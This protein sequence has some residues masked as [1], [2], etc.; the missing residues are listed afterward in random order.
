MAT[1][2]VNPSNKYFLKEPCE[3]IYTSSFQK[4]FGD[5]LDEIEQHTETT[6]LSDPTDLCIN[7]TTG[8]T[9]SRYSLSNVAVSQICRTLCPGLFKVICSLLNYQAGYDSAA[10]YASK[11]AYE[12]FNKVLYKRFALLSDKSIIKHTDNN[13][14]NGLIGKGYKYLSNI[15]FFDFVKDAI[16]TS[17]IPLKFNNASIYNRTVSI[18]YLNDKPISLMPN[19]YYMGIN[20]M[21]S[22][23]ADS[24]LK[25]SYILLEYNSNHRASTSV[26]GGR[27]IHTGRDFKKRV[28]KTLYAA[29]NNFNENNISYR[30]LITANLA[31]LQNTN[32]GFKNKSNI[33]LDEYRDKLESKLIQSKVSSQIA[34]RILNK[35]LTPSDYTGFIDSINAKVTWPTKTIYDFFLAVIKEATNKPLMHRFLLEKLAYDL[36]IGKSKLFKGIL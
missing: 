27:L 20:F 6:L 32:L 33:Q 2:S 7:T 35:T 29:V 3:L 36:L 13:E 14:I 10:T 19:T 24:S 28:I 26:K 23:I 9:I 12:I 4:A 16:A 31:K 22:E 15:K 11:E 8:Q 25:V 30:K 5:K 21:N 34:N 18:T 1:N 17:S